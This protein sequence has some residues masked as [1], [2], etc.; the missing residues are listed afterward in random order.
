M[1]L[2]ET[3]TGL[4]DTAPEQS[5]SLTVW[6]ML[7]VGRQSPGPGRLEEV[8]CGGKGLEDRAC[9]V[10]GGLEETGVGCP[11]FPGNAPAKWFSAFSTADKKSYK[12]TEKAGLCQGFAWLVF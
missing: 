8:G 9:R 3:E 6:G 12:E 5:G 10:S 7:G 4:R 1:L 2:L 11:A